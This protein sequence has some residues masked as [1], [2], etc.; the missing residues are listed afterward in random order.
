M[1]LTH[2]LGQYLINLYDLIFNI[3]NY[4]QPDFFH[5][6]IGSLASIAYI[7]I[8]VFAY[9]EVINKTEKGFYKILLVSFLIVLFLYIFNWIGD[10][11]FYYLNEIINKPIKE[12]QQNNGLHSLLNSFAGNFQKPHFNIVFDFFYVEFVIPFK[13]L[14]DSFLNLDFT[15]FFYIIFTSRL[16]LTTFV[17]YFFSLFYLF[18]DFNFN[19]VN[20]IIPIKNNLTLLNIA[21]KPT[22]WI[23]PIYIPFV[24]LI[25]KYFINKIISN[26][27]DKSI[28]FAVG[29]TLLPWFFYGKLTFDKRNIDKE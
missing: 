27:F 28:A 5:S 18:K 11:I 14:F 12:I 24:R 21:N 2:S 19:G 10:W 4:L 7:I 26:K 6:L 16:F 20:A 13:L 8:L 15:H 25:P 23:V 9:K 17:I 1:T 22:W 29:M 3:Q